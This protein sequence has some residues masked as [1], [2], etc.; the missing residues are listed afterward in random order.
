M[1]ASLL[2]HQICPVCDESLGEDGI[3]MVKNSSFPISQKVFM[4]FNRKIA[5][6][7]RRSIWFLSNPIYYADMMYAFYIVDLEASEKKK[8]SHMFI[9]NC[10]TRKM[11]PGNTTNTNQFLTMCI[12][13]AWMI[14]SQMKK[15]QSAMPQ[16]Y[17][18]HI[19]QICCIYIIHSRSPYRFS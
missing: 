8:A 14:F 13:Q 9:G 5:Q 6:F 3:R 7:L 4:C 10:M 17:I 19:H 2:L 15:I 16:K 1:T 11:L 18:Y 12:F